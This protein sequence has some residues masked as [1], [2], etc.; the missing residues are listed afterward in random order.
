[1][2]LQILKDKVSKF[3]V[4]LHC[5][6][7]PNYFSLLLLMPKREKNV[8]PYNSETTTL[9]PTLKAMNGA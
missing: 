7:L 9:F 6:N 1:M 8:A 2:A 4:I 5:K 3:E